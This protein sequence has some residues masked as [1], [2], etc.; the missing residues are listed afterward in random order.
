METQVWWVNSKEPE[1]RKQNVQ[2]VWSIQLY[3][4]A[5][6][7]CRNPGILEHRTQ[8]ICTICRQFWSYLYPVLIF[9]PSF[10]QVTRNVSN[11]CLL[12]NFKVT[13]SGISARRLLTKDQTRGHYFK[14]F[15]WA[16]TNLN[17]WSLVWIKIGLNNLKQKLSSA[18]F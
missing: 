11:C 10:I 8:T 14:K 7:S 17:L 9:C 2:T 5:N 12:L 18:D 6:Q 16:W 3:H 4:T 1:L 15:N 13:H